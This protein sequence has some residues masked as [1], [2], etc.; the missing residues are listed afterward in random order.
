[1]EEDWKELGL[2]IDLKETA[3]EV[4]VEEV[5]DEG[6]GDVRKVRAVL[7]GLAADR[8]APNAEALADR[9]I[10][11]TKKIIKVVQNSQLKV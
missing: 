10:I 2:Y 5:A 1:M 4:F 7:L 3:T 9:S 6:E 8:G 11:E